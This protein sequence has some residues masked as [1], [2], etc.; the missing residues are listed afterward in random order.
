MVQYVLINTTFYDKA[1][2]YYVTVE[3]P[4]AGDKKG[5][6]GYVETKPALFEVFKDVVVLLVFHMELIRR[7]EIAKKLL[8][9]HDTAPWSLLEA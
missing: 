2:E 8:P 4:M 3:R 7:K 9:Y 5:R 6:C 1:T